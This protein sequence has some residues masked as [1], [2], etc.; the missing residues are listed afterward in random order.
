MPKNASPSVASKVRHLAAVH[1]ISAS[2]DSTSR[3]ATTIT[4]LSG[5]TVVLD[6]VE[7]LLVNLKRKGVLTKAESLSLQADYLKEKRQSRR[8]VRA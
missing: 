4:R 7:Q 3:M 1:N 2:C 6:N 8:K 5:D